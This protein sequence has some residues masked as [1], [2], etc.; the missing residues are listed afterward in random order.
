MENIFSHP[1]VFSFFAL[2]IFFRSLMNSINKSFVYKIKTFVFTIKTF[3]CRNK[4][5]NYR[6]IKVK[7]EYEK[8]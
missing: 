2:N 7:K 8:G 5:F 4:T 3:I 1:S 6:I